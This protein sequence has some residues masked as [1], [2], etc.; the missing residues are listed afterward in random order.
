M[1]VLLRDNDQKPHGYP[2]EAAHLDLYEIRVERLWSNYLAN[3][4]R[5]AIGD[6]AAGILVAVCGNKWSALSFFMSA[7]KTSGLVYAAIFGVFI[8]AA[9]LAFWF[10]MKG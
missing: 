1:G 2:E 10:G 5:F 7:T 6:E 4:N 9:A 8:V 3:K